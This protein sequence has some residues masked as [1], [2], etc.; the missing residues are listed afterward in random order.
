GDRRAT[1]GG[2]RRHRARAAPPVRGARRPGQGTGSQ[3]HRGARMRTV[4]TKAKLR[5]AL[6]PA[7]RERR[8]IGLVPTMGYLHEGHL[9]LLHAARKRCDVV[10]MSLFVNPAQFGPGEDLERYPRDEARDAELA[11]RAGVDLIYAPPVEEVYP[12]GF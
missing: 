10:V 2:A 12:A 4:R 7:R 11:Q 5:D 3:R 1:P 6:E 9:S 8:T